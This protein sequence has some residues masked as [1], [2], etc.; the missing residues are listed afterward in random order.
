MDPLFRERLMMDRLASAQS[1]WG[2]FRL[3][4]YVRWKRLAWSAVYHGALGLKRLVDLVISALALVV[5][6]PLL[7][8]IAVAVRTD[9]GPALFRQTRVGSLGREFAMLKFRSMTVDAERRL[10]E[11]LP[12]NEKSD[13]ITFKMTDDPRVTRVGRFLRRWSLDE[14]PQ[15]WNVLTGVMSLVGPRPPLPGEVAHYSQADRRRLLV[16]PGITG[17][18]QV[19][20][21]RGRILEVGDRHAIAFPEQVRLDV[22]YIES[23]SVWKD[24]AILAKTIPAILLGRGL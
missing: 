3:I 22:R 16:K 12:R 10:A 23:Q 9:G 20:E 14:L 17:L 8:L 4:C 5:L 1:P 11:V 21:R 15:L 24:L 13:G 7:L 2:R 6:S 18:W 19:G